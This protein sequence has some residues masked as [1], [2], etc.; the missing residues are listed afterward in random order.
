MVEQLATTGVTLS[1]DDNVVA[2]LGTLLKSYE[3]LVV[4]LSLQN[5]LTLQTLVEKPHFLTCLR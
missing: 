5:V 1:Y 3:R 2:L 4:S